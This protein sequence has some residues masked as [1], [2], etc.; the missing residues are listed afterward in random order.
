MNQNLNQ[1]HQLH[2]DESW[3]AIVSAWV[4]GDSEIRS[5]D[6]NTPYGRQ[7]WDTYHMIGDVI[8]SDDLSIKP[9][10]MFYAR[11]S[12][13][14]DQEPTII[15]PQHK[16]PKH[17]FKSVIAAAVVSVAFG[18]AWIS[19]PESNPEINLVSLASNQQAASDIST[20]KIDHALDEYYDAHI[21]MA[22]SVPVMQVSYSGSQP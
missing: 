13:A 21:D 16:L 10:D 2:T 18:I 22:G 7:V 3:D 14:I 8:R 11:L 1:N 20:E 12:R 17:F 19:M 6:L 9:S 4:D 5:E 15:A